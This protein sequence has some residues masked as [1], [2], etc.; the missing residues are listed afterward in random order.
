ME[1]IKA[2]P[3]FTLIELVITLSII[4][5]LML[6]MFPQFQD[7]TD[8]AKLRTFEYNCRSVSYAIAVYQAEH[9][10]NL[11]PTESDLDPYLNG[12]WA[13]LSGNPTGATYSWNGSQLQA[14]YQD[15]NGTTHS[16]TYPD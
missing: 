14:S 12:G 11:P 6:M 3:G 10:G 15:L 16:F 7:V 5:I 2:R 1:R 13:S 4:G 9:D 8:A